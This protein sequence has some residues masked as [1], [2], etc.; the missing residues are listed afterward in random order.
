MYKR[1]MTS[2]KMRIIV[3]EGLNAIIMIMSDF[4]FFQAIKTCHETRLLS[5][6][7]LQQTEV[8]FSNLS[9]NLKTLQCRQG[10]NCFVLVLVVG[11]ESE[12]VFFFFFAFFLPLPYISLSLLSLP[13]YISLSSSPSQIIF[14]KQKETGYG[15]KNLSLHDPQIFYGILYLQNKFWFELFKNIVLNFQLQFHWF[16]IKKTKSNCVNYED[17]C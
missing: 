15:R 17:T 16:D 13:P 12:K 8:L 1:E 5:R 4:F 11:K 6:F 7:M 10:Y 9:H 14:N 2:W 3:V